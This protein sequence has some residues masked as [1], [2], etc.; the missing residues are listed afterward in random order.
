[1]ILLRFWMTHTRP[2]WGLV[3]QQIDQ[4]PKEMYHS[5]MFPFRVDAGSGRYSMEPRPDILIH[6]RAILD[7]SEVK[8]QE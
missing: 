4:E 1:M 6:R 5:A 8:G 7:V 2:P 3:L